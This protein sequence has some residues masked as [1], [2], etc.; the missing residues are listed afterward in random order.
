MSV[1]IRPFDHSE[2]SP[3]WAAQRAL[4]ERVYG[5]EVAAR[6]ERALRWVTLGNPVDLAE[7]RRYV[8]DLGG[9]MAATLGRMP[10]RI[11][12]YGK[13]GL[14]RY[15]HDLLVDPEYRGQ[16]LAQRLVH[17]VAT[18]S[19]SP[20]GGL[21]MNAP[22]YAIH[23]KC[24]W[25]AMVPGYAQ[26]RFLDTEGA[27]AHR[28]P[29][30]LAKVA[31]VGLKMALA[32]TSVDDW[33]AG[34]AGLTVEEVES[35]APGADGLW[36]ET[37][38]LLGVAAVRDN[39][40]LRWRFDSPPNVPYVRLVARRKEVRRGYLALRLPA[41][42]EAGTAAVAVDLLALPDE[43]EVITAL[44]REALR[45]ARVANASALVAYTTLSPFRR[46]LARLGFVRA[47]KPQTFV[48]NNFEGRPDSEILCDSSRWYLTFADSDGHMW[49]GAQPT[50]RV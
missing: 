25:K 46:R 1:I 2:D 7:E 24:K 11:T 47:P 16:E 15:S 12:V 3:D 21:W 26:I 30:P 49:A 14:L 40:Y 35:F 17:E 34:P 20:V 23:R 18:Q 50:M 13:P 8:A 37:S 19:D 38:P 4:F 5:P 32:F 42:G 48:L 39:E 10:V 43:P 31:G 28:M 45:R 36:S 27:L 41:P 6:R 29:A 9:R 33:S 44:M 22:S